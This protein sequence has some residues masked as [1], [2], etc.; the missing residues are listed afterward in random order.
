MED[1]NTEGE[2][3]VTRIKVNFANDL[4]Y[5]YRDIVN[6]FVGRGDVVLEMG[7]VHRSVPNQGTISDRVVLSL[8]SAYEFH[9]RLGKALQ[10]A[11]VA[12]QKDTSQTRG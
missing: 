1:R 11:Q 12:M 10:E 9:T 7:N 5:K 8:A 6:I 3:P 2:T 4:D